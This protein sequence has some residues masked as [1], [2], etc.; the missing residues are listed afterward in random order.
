MASLK[1]TNVGAA[2]LLPFE[3]IRSCWV[4]FI[5]FLGGFLRLR[6][7]FGA[8]LCRIFTLDCS[9]IKMLLFPFIYYAFYGIYDVRMF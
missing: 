4:F 9:V 3:S 2:K 7:L 6:Q 1:A 8:T 5:Y